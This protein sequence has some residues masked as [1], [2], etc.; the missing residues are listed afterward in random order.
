MEVKQSK[1][2]KELSEHGKYY[3]QVNRN[4]VNF[5]NVTCCFLLGNE[6][7]DSGSNINVI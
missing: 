6:N 1:N 3:I 2:I 7:I 5:M 4:N